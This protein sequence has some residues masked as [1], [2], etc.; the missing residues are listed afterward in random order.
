[1]VSDLETL[2]I[3]DLCIIVYKNKSLSKVFS[4]GLY[5]FFISALKKK[6]KYYISQCGI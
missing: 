1:M 5:F 4:A 2:F 6:K 3:F